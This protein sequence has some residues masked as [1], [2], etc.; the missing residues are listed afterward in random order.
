MQVL[1]VNAIR[2]YNLDPDINH[3]ECASIFNAAGMYMMIDV[4][5]PLPGEAITSFE[6]WTSYY[7]EYLNRTFAIVEAFSNYPNTLLFFSGN[8]IIN[9]LPSAEF[10]PPYMR[11]ITRDLKNY[12]KNNIDRQVSLLLMR[13]RLRCLLTFLVPDPCWLLCCRCP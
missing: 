3:D 2:V 8:E 1:G 12:I 6:P 10:V 9:D 11:A 13:I 5:S 4:N 7:A